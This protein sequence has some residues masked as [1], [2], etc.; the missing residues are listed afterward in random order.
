M[1]GTV[2]N[3]PSQTVLPLETLPASSLIL[4]GPTVKLNTVGET[5]AAYTGPREMVI[6]RNRMQGA[7]LQHPV[8]KRLGRHNFY[9]PCPVLTN[10]MA[11]VCV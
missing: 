6:I 5:G 4:Y 2:E 1:K 8:T 10:T 7:A 3:M 9:T 11:R